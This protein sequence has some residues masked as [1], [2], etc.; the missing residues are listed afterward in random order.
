MRVIRKYEMWIPEDLLY[1]GKTLSQIESIGKKLDHD[2]NTVGFL[3]RFLKENKLTFISIR[4]IIKEKKWWFIDMFNMI[5]ELPDSI[6][7][8][9]DTM[10]KLVNMRINNKLQDK[11]IY[12]ILSGF[13]IM[14]IS[15]FLFYLFNRTEL[16]IISTAGL[17]F[18]F[19]IFLFEIFRR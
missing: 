8:I 16:K 6:R 18:S 17:I 19:L 12:R 9:N 1:L 11:A 13:G 7:R 4:E 2:F 15:I 10:D 5:M 14:A 3:K